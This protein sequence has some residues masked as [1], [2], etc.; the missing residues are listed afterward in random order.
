MSVE[1]RDQD[2][3][4]S[5][6]PS[7]VTG[8]SVIGQVTA[9][10]DPDPRMKGAVIKV[11][12]DQEL[13][14]LHSLPNG[15]APEIL[16]VSEATEGD[17]G[18]GSTFILMRYVGPDLG[19]LAREVVKGR[20]QRLTPDQIDLTL[21]LDLL[22]QL[23]ALEERG[24]DA[25]QLR[26]EHVLVDLQD[27]DSSVRL[28]GFGGASIA[29]SAPGPEHLRLWAEML[30]KEALWQLSTG[31]KEGTNPEALRRTLYAC[32][33][34]DSSG[35][36]SSACE[37]R[38]LATAPVAQPSK[39]VRPAIPP[40][41]ET[42]PPSPIERAGHYL[43]RTQWRKASPYNVVLLLAA[44]AGFIIGLTAAASLLGR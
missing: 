26:A 1:V 37:A 42:L 28:C 39:N 6:D 24:I 29:A 18:A 44:V 31:G 25:T 19:S 22:D 20:A 14:M 32:L 17:I 10:T 5:V 36:P 33:Q 16:R 13:S 9:T 35:R 12:G 11:V 41:A 8:T 38:A 23:A 2:Y 15:V 27:S 30:Q 43:N 21:V 40:P 7:A 3:R 4:Y 34:D